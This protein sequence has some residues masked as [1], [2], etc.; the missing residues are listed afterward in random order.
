MIWIFRHH[1]LQAQSKLPQKPK[2]MAHYI[3]LVP[4]SHTLLNKLRYAASFTIGQESNA[5][6]KIM[7]NWNFTNCCIH[8]TTQLHLD[9]RLLDIPKMDLH[10]LLTFSILLLP[11]LCSNLIYIIF[12][13]SSCNRP[14]LLG[15]L[16]RQE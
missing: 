3:T 6:M 4:K 9:S 12:I 13:F 11:L 10:L 15:F 14:A 1:L 5:L 8:L 16:S 2:R 7:D